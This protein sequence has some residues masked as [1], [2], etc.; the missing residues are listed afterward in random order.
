MM[1]THKLQIGILISLIFLLI[2]C[3]S[4]ALDSVE[5]K[6][7]LT[8]LGKLDAGTQVGIN[9]QEYSRLLLEGQAKVNEATEKLPEGE[10]RKELLLAIE[11]YKDAQTIWD[12]KDLH[13]VEMQKEMSL[14]SGRDSKEFDVE[15]WIA[16]CVGPPPVSKNE[17][18][19]AMLK[20]YCD[21]KISRL[22]TT[23]KIPLRDHKGESASST[24]GRISRQEGL[25]LIWAS[26]R[27]HVANVKAM[28]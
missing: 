7:A 20:Q 23:Y 28:R 22:V 13:I 24:M 12:R 21:D 16:A 15:K 8:A 5:V 6:E 26:G 1:R 19:N 2:G 10:L 18:E 9:R 4:S 17:I 3:N 27:V 25:D 14:L 11:S